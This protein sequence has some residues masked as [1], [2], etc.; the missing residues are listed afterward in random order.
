MG[1]KL[2]PHDAWCGFVVR[3]VW[4]CQKDSSN[5]THTVCF[6]VSIYRP[7]SEPDVTNERMT[8]LLKLDTFFHTHDARIMTHDAS[9]IRTTH[10]VDLALDTCKPKRKSSTTFFISPS[11]KV[12][13]RT[14]LCSQKILDCSPCHL[15]SWSMKLLRGAW[16]FFQK[17]NF[18]YKKKEKKIFMSH[19]FS[20]NE[21]IQQNYEQEGLKITSYT[22]ITYVCT[23]IV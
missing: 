7:I 20:N 4:I 6:D 12:S 3:H 19:L 11:Q 18:L 13:F 16:N 15:N 14:L 9:P 22:K 17:Y 8:Y 23:K 1:L 21:N 5:P 2:G 10:R